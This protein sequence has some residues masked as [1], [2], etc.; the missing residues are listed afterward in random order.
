M[1]DER[2]SDEL[3]VANMKVDEEGKNKFGEEMVAQIADDTK[4]RSKEEIQYAVEMSA[5]V[6]DGIKAMEEEAREPEPKEVEEAKKETSDDL[7]R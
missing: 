3:E 5:R 2:P 1:S 4:H 7:E 6:E